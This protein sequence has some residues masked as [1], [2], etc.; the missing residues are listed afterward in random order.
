MVWLGEGGVLEGL[1][2]VEEGKEV[3]LVVVLGII[4]E[5]E[6]DFFLEVGDIIGF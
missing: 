4:L 1:V 6:L 2:E 3:E 5:D